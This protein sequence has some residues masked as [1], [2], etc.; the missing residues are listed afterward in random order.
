MEAHITWF[1]KIPLTRPPS[2]VCSSVLEEDVGTA[3]HDLD[4]AVLSE[5]WAILSL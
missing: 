3:L 2:Q 5:A 4:I 1:A